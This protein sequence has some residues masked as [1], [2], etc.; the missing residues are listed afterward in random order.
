MGVRWL[1]AFRP[2]EQEFEQV[3]GVRYGES[4]WFAVNFTIPFARLCVK[5]ERIVLRVS[6]IG[7]TR[8]TFEFLKP[9]IRA[10]RWK[11]GIFSKGLLIEHAKPDYPPFILFWTSNRK[12]LGSALSGLGYDLPPV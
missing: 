2:M 6:F 7:L 5:R 1:V 8:R 11:R 12:A 9:E 3:G 10:L 4:V